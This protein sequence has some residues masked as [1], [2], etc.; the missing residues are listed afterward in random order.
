MSEYRHVTL[1]DVATKTK[2]SA[3]AREIEWQTS[4]DEPAATALANLLFNSTKTYARGYEVVV[5][6]VYTLDDF[7]AG[8]PRFTLAFD[9]HPAAGSAIY[10]AIAASI[11]Y[12][13][14]RT[15]FTVRG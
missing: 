1:T 12:G 9:R 11:D 4:L 2:F 7:V 6:D 5:E 13:A 8:F 15:T 14:N 3:T 10:T